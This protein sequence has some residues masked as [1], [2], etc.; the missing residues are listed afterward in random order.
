MDEP[1]VTKLR[2]RISCS[3]NAATPTTYPME[4]HVTSLL[5]PHGCSDAG[6]WLVLLNQSHFGL[7]AEQI[8]G[9]YYQIHMLQCKSFES[10]NMSCCIRCQSMEALKDK[11]DPRAKRSLEAIA[12][13]SILF[14]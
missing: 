9:S 12:I 6:T 14:I 1:L 13:S 11:G 3:C 4:L 7:D 5:L 2:S 10:H 8:A